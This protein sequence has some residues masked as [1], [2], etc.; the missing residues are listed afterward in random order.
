MP[1]ATV[2]LRPGINVEMTPVLNE[3]GYSQSGFG[4]FKAGLFQK[5]GG[6]TKYY[7]Y[8]LAGTVRALH[9]WQDLNA[10]KHLGVG[11]TSSLNILTS[12]SLNTITPQQTTTNPAPNFSTVNGSPTVTVVDTGIANVTTL[13]YVYFNTPISVGG[14]ILSGIYA[15]QTIVGTTSYTI[16]A[17]SNATSTVNNTGSVPSFAAQGTTTSLVNVTLN[18]HGLVAGAEITFPIATTAYGITIQGTYSVVSVTN[19]NVFVISANAFL[20]STSSFSMNSGN[21]QLL[22]Y[23]ALG[24]QAGGSGYGLLGYG[25]TSTATVTISISTP[26]D[27]TWT[28]HGFTAGQAVSFSTSVGGSLPT[29]ITA[30]TTYYIST[31]G[32]TTDSFRIATTLANAL[33]GTPVVNTSGTQSGTQTGSAAVGGYGTGYAPTSQTGT[34]ISTTNW[35]LDNFGELLVSCPKDGAIY[36]YD[37]NGGYAT[38]QVVPNSPVFNRGIFVAMPEQQIVAYGSSLTPAG[39]I[40]V[41]QDPLLIRWCD[42]GD[43]TSWTASATNQAGSYH[44]PTGSEIIGAIQSAQNGLIW[45]DLDLWAMSYI[46]QPL[47]YA[48]NKIGSNC[49]LIGNHARAQLL[50]VTYWMGRSNFFM[51]S[52]SGVTPIPCSVWDYVFQDLDTTNQSKCVAAADTAF[53]EV[54]FFFPSASG[55]TGEI[56]KYVKFNTEEKTWDY[57]VLGRTAWTDQSVLGQPIGAGS[58]GYIYQ[59]ETTNDADGVAINSVFQSGYW[60]MA[61]GEEIVFVD[62]ILPDFKW[63]LYGSSPNAQ[64]QITIYA[65]M[66]PGDVPQIYGPYTVTQATQYINTRIRAR[67]MAIQVSSADLGSFWR[68]GGI[69]VR[70]SRDGRR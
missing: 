70:S 17:A 41:Q 5:I 19:A 42:V 32:L 66:Y 49:G 11:S 20:T 63:G 60:M 27:I 67:Y 45:T 50:G 12:G 57:G 23:I 28:A 68:I 53:N 52:G 43:F 56:D 39:S 69:K 14:L 26:A 40:G 4:R 6:W 59:H 64:I 47:I 58:D 35:T 18:N 48:F 29:G 61:E 2:K 24:P 3:A 13:D 15:I 1:F 38:A 55:G 25:G 37:V 7:T 62:W 36:Y 46:G 21:A 51:L 54:F 65:T 30:G 31:A 8:A 9:P 22:Y 33:A 44:I 16:T 10:V 34:A